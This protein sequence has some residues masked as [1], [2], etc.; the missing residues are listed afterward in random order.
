[1]NGDRQEAKA[2]PA[3]T[4]V[5]DSQGNPVA[6]GGTTEDT[7]LTLSGIGAANTVVFIFDNG[8]LL[9]SASVTINS[10]WRFS[11]TVGLGRHVFTVR[12]GL[13]GVDSPSWV[14]SVGGAALE[15]QIQRVQDGAGNDIPRGGT[16]TN[17]NLALTGTA[18]V[19]QGV[20]IFDGTTLLKTETATGGT[21]T[22]SLSG[23]AARQYNFKA[24]ALYG[25]NP[26]SEVWG[27][28]VVATWAREDFEAEKI[29]LI[30]AVPYI[31]ASGLIIYTH[32]QSSLQFFRGSLGTELL[33]GKNYGDLVLPVPVRRVDF[34]WRAGSGMVNYL[35]DAGRDLGSE[36]FHN[37]SD[38]ITQHL[39]RFNAPA[40][41][42][43]S[44]LR[45]SL[46]ASIWMD[47]LTW[48]T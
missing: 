21:W 38:V 33:G 27:V 5:V 9:A 37:D 40:G 4:N 32:E 28:N 17:N 48:Y 2:D 43:I 19:G 30:K 44:E 35:N 24:R 26:E 11:E 22:C 16:T 1:M 10:T 29:G 39:V 7:V 18:A 15:P 6:N 20:Q 47:E 41:Q 42:L 23:L 31:C 36:K 13:Q 46:R 34:I 3:V 8:A 45:F 14:V 12:D 25:S